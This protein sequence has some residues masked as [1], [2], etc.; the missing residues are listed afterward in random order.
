M[1]SIYLS[2]LYQQYIA[3]I[4]CFPLLQYSCTSKPSGGGIKKHA[5]MHRSVLLKRPVRNT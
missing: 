5:L 2:H 3:L 4:L 1:E